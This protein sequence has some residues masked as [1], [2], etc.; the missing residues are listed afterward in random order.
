MTI[1]EAMNTT[2]VFAKRDRMTI[3]VVERFE[4]PPGEF[5]L[6]QVHPPC[7]E[8][9]SGNPYLNSPKQWPAARYRVAISFEDLLEHF[10]P[11]RVDE[12]GVIVYAGDD[13]GE[14][15]LERVPPA[16]E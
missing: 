14:P 5:V 1:T 16:G 15:A 10:E 7:E 3:F 4:M 9:D 6:R 8:T 13:S 2:L 11:C 12:R